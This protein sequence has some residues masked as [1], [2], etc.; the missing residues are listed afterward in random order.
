MRATIRPRAIIPR[1]N[2]VGQC[3]V[4]GRCALCAVVDCGPL[5]R[6]VQEALAAYCYYVQPCRKVLLGMQVPPEVSCAAWRRWWWRRWWL[7]AAG[8]APLIPPHH[9]PR[10]PGAAIPSQFPKPRS[11]R[12]RCGAG[13]LA[14]SCCGR[15]P[16]TARPRHSSWRRR[17]AACLA[18]RG[19][20]SR[21]GA[22]A[23]AGEGAACER[24]GG[25]TAC[26]PDTLGV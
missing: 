3:A 18:W 11:W 1:Y 17:R 24:S 15:L 10:R 8:A 2:M 14:G 20:V 7:P 26:D 13:A 9:I 16:R 19:A 25:A 23:A 12:G 5:P 6:T 21:C 4:C 22:G